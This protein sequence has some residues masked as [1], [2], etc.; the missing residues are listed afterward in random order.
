MHSPYIFSALI[1]NM[2]LIGIVTGFVSGFMGAGTGVIIVPF[3]VW[4]FNHIL[5]YNLEDCF[6]VA[7]S[8]SIAVM[9]VS[10]F[11]N[12]YFRRNSVKLDKILVKNLII[13]VSFTSVIGILLKQ[14]IPVQMYRIIITVILIYFGVKT[15][16]TFK[17]TAVSHEKSFINHILFYAKCGVVYIITVIAGTG[18]GKMMIPIFRSSGIDRTS[19]IATS[20]FLAIFNCLV[21]TMLSIIFH[22]N[23][24]KIDY[25]IGSIYVLGFVVISVSSLIPMYFGIMLGEKMKTH[26]CDYIFS[27][28][29]FFS[30]A[31]VFFTGLG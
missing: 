1:I 22:K 17:T 30:A 31:L 11:F 27:G 5:H 29:L 16:Q 19:A 7:T 18:S 14:Y 23:V 28:F 4:Y 3:L 25:S 12:Y 24:V 9:A 15:A 8:T 6:L 21:I 26:I 10:S 13:L 20:K 2:M